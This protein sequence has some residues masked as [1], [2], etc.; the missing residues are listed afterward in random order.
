MAVKT[1]FSLVINGTEVRTLG[2]LRDN[3]DGG[4]LAGHLRDGSLA[5]WL[6]DR[7]LDDE[8]AAVRSL[9]PEGDGLTVKLARVFGVETNET[10]ETD[11]DERLAR[12]REFTSDEELLAK[13]DLAAFDQEELLERYDEGRTEVILCGDDFEIPRSKQGL[14]Y[15]RLSKA[16]SGSDGAEDDGLGEMIGKGA[17]MLAVGAA[18]ALIGAALFGIISTLSDDDRDPFDW[19]APALRAFGEAV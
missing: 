19:G 1:R 13:V 14:S 16:A 6:E 4:A 11:R 15:I 10:D 9:H 7:Y 5:R 2:E 17:A 3:F 8:A 12:L 18:G